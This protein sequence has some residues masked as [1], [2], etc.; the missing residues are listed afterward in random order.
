MT[1]VTAE[2]IVV[3]RLEYGGGF[4]EDLRVRR[5]WYRDIELLSA[6]SLERLC[7]T[8]LRVLG[9]EPWHLYEFMIGDKKYAEL[10]YDDSLF[11]EIE[12][13]TA[14]C[15]APLCVLNLCEGQKIVRL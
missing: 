13:V 1:A 11:V 3:L 12:D 9:W 7:E 5:G 10:G 8:I 14:S 15:R 6:S 4:G 2:T